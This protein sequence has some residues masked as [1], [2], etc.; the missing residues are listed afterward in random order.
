MI[1][2]LI[3]LVLTRP[4]SALGQ[5]AGAWESGELIAQSERTKIITSLSSVLS[6][7]RMVPQ[8]RPSCG[9]E[10]VARSRVPGATA[11]V[12]II[13][14]LVAEPPFPTGAGWRLQAG[15]L[16]REGLNLCL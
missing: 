7:T 11:K 14:H 8:P 12:I 2:L 16:G 10:P 6:A 1:K 5:R 9:W 4:K 13:Y 3:V 15:R